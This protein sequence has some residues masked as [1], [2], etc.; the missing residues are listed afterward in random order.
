MWW[1]VE[2]KKYFFFAGDSKAKRKTGGTFCR[3]FRCSRCHRIAFLGANFEYPVIDLSCCSGVQELPK[4]SSFVNVNHWS[5][6]AGDAVQH[7]QKDLQL[8]RDVGSL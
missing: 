3:I 8:D 6:R 7:L 1:V 5:R 2:E 4:L